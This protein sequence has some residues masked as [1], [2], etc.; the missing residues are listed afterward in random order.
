VSYDTTK[1]P[2]AKL[3]AEH[4]VHTPD[5][6][7]FHET[8]LDERA[9]KHRAYDVSLA[10]RH[11]VKKVAERPWFFKLYRA[12]ALNVIAPLFGNK[13]SYNWPPVFR[14][15][16]AGARS[17]SALHRDTEVTGRHDLIAV[18]VPFVDA[19]GAN[20]IW[21]ET[22]YGNR[23]F[24]P[25]EVKYGQALMFDSGYLW[26]CSVSNSTDVTRFSMDFRVSPKRTDLDEPDLGIFTPRPKG[27][28][29]QLE[30]PSAGKQYDRVQKITWDET[31]PQP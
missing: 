26:H 15:H 17:I 9:D 18:W 30:P 22:A 2:F 6:S 8:V 20:S 7:R 4:V 23:D 21:I 13:M 1:Y 5:L 11:R 14:V 24:A 27:Y 10:T 16:L 12:F 3:F 29:A 25:V 28:A 31:S 19:F